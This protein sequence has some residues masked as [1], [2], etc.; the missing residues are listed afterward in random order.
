M[1]F[2]IIFL[3][4]ILVILFLASV[5]FGGFTNIICSPT[6]FPIGVFSNYIYPISFCY[7][8]TETE[9]DVRTED[10]SLNINN[11]VDRGDVLSGSKIQVLNQEFSDILSS[12]SQTTDIKQLIDQNV[13]INCDF[14]DIEESGLINKRNSSDQKMY[15]CCPVFNQEA[16][17][18]IVVISE[19]TEEQQVEMINKIKA[20]VTDT[21]REQGK[22]QVAID[23]HVEN[24]NKVQNTL[25]TNVQSKVNQFISQQSVSEQEISYTDNIGMCFNGESRVM[26]QKSVLESLSMNIITSSLDIIMK[27]DV[28]IV[29]ETDTTVVRVSNWVILGSL[30]LDIFC[31]VLCFFIISSMLSDSE[32]EIEGST[33]E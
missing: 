2:V 10:G 30:V 28:G 22:D 29:A 18:K 20:K 1:N 14:I 26:E 31:L 15:G 19:I 33:N 25:I 16:V 7:E 8:N 21:L 24:M 5:M 4:V 12:N 13:V 9:V 6:S 32:V 23:A 17:E 27:N 3:I 11:Q